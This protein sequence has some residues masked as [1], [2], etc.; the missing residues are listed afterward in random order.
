MD[1]TCFIG[2]WSKGTDGNGSKVRTILFDY[3][4]AFDLIDHCILI[5]KLCM[6]DMPKS[7]I[8]WIIDFLSNRFQR[9]KLEQ[10]CFS[11]WGSVPSGV[12]QGTKLGPW[13]F[14][15]MINELVVDD[16]NLWK[17][18]DDT[19]VSE[20]DTKGEVGNAQRYADRVVQ[21]SINNGVQL[22]TDKCK[23]LRISFAKN[24]QEFVPISVNDKN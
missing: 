13:L 6:L 8:I 24:Q 20:I 3:R 7:I 16:T 11:E 18:V 1:H 19:T 17:Y 14:I 9:I 22:N 5:D 15:L 4:K 21:W 2:H 12:S 10:G 23:E